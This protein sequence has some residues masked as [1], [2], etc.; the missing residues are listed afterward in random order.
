MAALSI[1]LH[2]HWLG[3]SATV[4]PAMLC[5]LVMQ[6]QLGFTSVTQSDKVILCSL[7]C[8]AA[9]TSQI[10]VMLATPLSLHADYQPNGEAPMSS[11]ALA[12]SGTVY[13]PKGAKEYPVPRAMTTEEIARVVD[14]FR[15]A[16]RNSLDAGFDGVE[17]HSANGY[18]LDQFLKVCS[19]QNTASANDSA[20]AA[21][22]AHASLCMPSITSQSWPKQAAINSLICDMRQNSSCQATD[23]W[24]AC[25]RSQ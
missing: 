25:C 21:L 23:Q 8:L 6:V 15:Q 18:I 20:M 16:A 24:R 14:E 9:L 7:C 19:K 13:T 5:G 2:M 4:W 10:S 1:H 11:S 12:A 22:P 17:I 3:C